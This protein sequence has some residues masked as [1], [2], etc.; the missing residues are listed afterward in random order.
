MAPGSEPPRLRLGFREEIR[1]REG[2]WVCIGGGHC[3]VVDGRMDVCMKTRSGER[4]R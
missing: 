3:L 4:R 2:S 1:W